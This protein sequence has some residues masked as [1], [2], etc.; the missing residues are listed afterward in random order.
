MI[1]AA[2]ELYAWGL[3]SSGGALGDGTNTNK[4]RPTRICIATPTTSCA[5]NW[6]E[7]SA[8]VYHNLAINAAGELYAWGY[9]AHGQLGDGGGGRVNAR[10]IISIP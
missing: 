4:N 10:S 2:G 3:N 9:N 5:T 7:I 1:N 8:G 6:K